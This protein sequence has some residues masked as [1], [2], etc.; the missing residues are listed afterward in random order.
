MEKTRIENDSTSP[1]EF[2]IVKD[3]YNGGASYIG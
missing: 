3:Y 2:D 1:L